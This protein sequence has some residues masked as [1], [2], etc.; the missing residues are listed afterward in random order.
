L[1]ASGCG[2]SLTLQCIAG[3]L[4]PDEGYIK[5]GGRTLFDADRK[6]NLP[7]KKR[8]VGYMF[9]Q[10]A[11]FPNMTVLQNV[12]CGV[13][14]GSHAEKRAE[15][16]KYI[17]ISR[18]SGLERK[19]P[20]EL[21]GGER[22]RCALARLLVSN[23]EVILMD[24]PFSALDDY[25]RWQLELELADTLRSFDG[26]SV[27]VSH[28]RDEVYR[29]C[30]SVCVLERGHS[31]SAR[32]VHALFR[33]P[34]T[35]SASLISGCKNY[36]RA[37]RTPDN[38]VNAL[39]WGVT[40]T[41]DGD[42]PDDMRFIGVRA[43]FIHPSHDNDDVNVIPCEVVRV[44][45]DVLNTVVMLATPIGNTGYSLLRAEM[46][47]ETWAS[48]DNPKTLPVSIDKADIMMLR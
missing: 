40:L 27:F 35:L 12:M 23:P 15:A 44:I 25:L 21:S 7:P 11:L 4:S 20:A 1:G 30:N 28:S 39:D 26:P 19:K 17:A 22:Q 34:V 24:E 41:A 5:L 6:I 31:E 3:V 2:K 37:E 38:R 10:Y 48:L 29:I 13:R 47:K 18:L 16:E 9:Q 33:E 43:H 14:G 8:N 32:E 45:D 36:S 42:I 46:P